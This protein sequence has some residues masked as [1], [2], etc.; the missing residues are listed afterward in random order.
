M[1]SAFARA[2]ARASRVIDAKHGERLRFVPKGSVDNWGKPTG[3]ADGRFPVDLIG[4]IYEGAA[5]FMF[6]AGDKEN[7]EFS[8]QLV[9]QAMHASVERR[10][11]APHNQPRKG[12]RIE[13]LD[14]A[15][16]AYTITLVVSDGPSRFAFILVQTK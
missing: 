12:D 11:F 5:D 10:H 7:N 8:A 14:R 16:E 13:A 1:Q 6:A 4:G 2:V 9:N 3:V 15:C